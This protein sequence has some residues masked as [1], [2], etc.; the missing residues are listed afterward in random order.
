MTGWD[1]SATQAWEGTSAEAPSGSRKLARP[2]GKST[3]GTGKGEPK[4][5]RQGTC[6]VCVRKAKGPVWLERG[7]GAGNQNRWE[8]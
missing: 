1:G 2:A 3:V 4:S 7:K 8:K 6:V 5:P